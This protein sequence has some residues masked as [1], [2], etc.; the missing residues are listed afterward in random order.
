MFA[1]FGFVSGPMVFI[2]LKGFFTFMVQIALYLRGD[3]R[4]GRSVIREKM[5]APQRLNEWSI[6]FQTIGLTSTAFAYAQITVAAQ[7]WASWCGFQTWSLLVSQHMGTITLLVGL[8]SNLIAAVLI[9][10][11]GE[12]PVCY[13]E[14]AVGRFLFFFGLAVGTP[15]WLALG[16]I[17]WPCII[18][19]GLTAPVCMKLIF[20]VIGE[21][22]FDVL[23]L[24][25]L[26]QTLLFKRDSWRFEGVSLWALLTLSSCLCIALLSLLVGVNR[27]DTWMLVGATVLWLFLPL[28]ATAY[29]FSFVQETLPAQMMAFW[30][31]MSIV[32]VIIVTVPASILFWERDI[33]LTGCAPAAFMGKQ[34]QPFFEHTFFLPAKAAL[35]NV[36]LWLS[37]IVSFFT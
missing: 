25:D 19:L 10:D 14:R 2:F 37:Q 4:R 7:P 1:R 12:D 8:S 27:G 6:V 35:E 33:G 31:S 21:R 20:K 23:T 26:V 32:Y 17:A 11:D 22:T 34:V 28:I 9:E 16:F 30:T 24:E 18:L 15:V 5:D 13:D 3:I 36:V 29:A